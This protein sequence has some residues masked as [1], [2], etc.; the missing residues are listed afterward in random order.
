MKKNWVMGR[1]SILFLTLFV[2]RVPV[3]AQTATPT[4]T[5]TGCWDPA[6]GGS[7]ELKTASPSGEHDIALTWTSALD[8][9]SYYLLS[10][11]MESGKYIYGNPNMGGQGTTSYTVGGLTKGKTYYFAVRAGNGCTPGTFSNELSAV[12]GETPTPTPQPEADRPLDD[13]PTPTPEPPAPT[14]TPTPVP[15]VLAAETSSTPGSNS[16]IGYIMLGATA[17]GILLVLVSGFLLL[18][19]KKASS[20]ASNLH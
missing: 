14:A 3:F 4:L 16:V 10:Y 19:M 17:F 6:P 1:A 12:A 2:F 15:Q 8:P 5:P 18:R 9:V 7:V 13:T 20:S 11:G